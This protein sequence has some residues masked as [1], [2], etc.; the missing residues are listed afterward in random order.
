MESKAVKRAG[1]TLALVASVALANSVYVM[2]LFAA[3]VVPD[4]LPDGREHRTLHDPLY[5]AL[6]PLSFLPTLLIGTW[7][8]TRQSDRWGAHGKHLL[9]AAALAFYPAA[10]CAQA[11]VER[12]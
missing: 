2:W 12:A 9:V 3:E 10:L 1:I 5:Y 11:L 8:I 7:A 6:H 4:Q